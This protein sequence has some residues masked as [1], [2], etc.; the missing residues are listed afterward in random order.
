MRILLVEDDEML[1]D[2]LQQSLTNQH[3][4]VDLATDGQ[5]GLDYA[6]SAEYDLIVIDVGLPR[7]DGITLCQRLRSLGC[8]TPI[9]LMTARDATSDRIRGLDAGADD[10]LTKPLNLAE[11]Q[12]RVRALLRRSSVSTS[13]V[14]QVGQLCLNPS[15]C[16]VSYGDKPLSLTPK[17]YSLLELFLRNPARVF[18]R[19]QILQHLWT[20]DD[21]PLEESVKAHIKGLRQKLKTAGAVDWIENVYGIG[22]RLKEGV[23]EQLEENVTGAIAKASAK[24]PQ[25]EAP[26]DSPANLAIAQQQFNQAMERLWEQYGDLMVQRLHVLRRMATAVQQDE[27]TAELRRDAERA[28]HKLAGVLGMFEKDDGT[29]LAREIEDI[30]DGDQV[31]KTTQKERLVELVSALTVLMEQHL[32]ESFITPETASLLLIDVDPKLGQELQALGRSQGR[33]WYQSTTQTEVET[34]LRSH[35]PELVVLAIDSLGQSASLALLADLV[36]RTPAIPVL[37]LANDDDLL[38]RVTIARSGGQGFLV[39]PVTA[40]QVWETTT[41]LLQRARSAAINVLVVDDDPVFLG[42]VRSL[43]EPWGIHMTG[44]DDP[45]R[46]W[47]TLQSVQPDL[48]ILDVEMPELSGIELC[49]AVRT[50]P[51]WQ[52]LP[53]LFLTAHKDSQIVQQVFAAGAD[54]FIIKPVVGPELLTRINN[55]LERNRLLKTLSTTEPITGLANQRQSSQV[56]E[57][58]LQQATK[59]GQPFSLV[60]LSIADLRQIN[61]QFS[62]TAGNQVLQQWGR[63]F[64]TAFRGNEIVGYWGNGEFVVGLP[65]VTQTAVND[66]LADVLKTLRRQV[67]TAPN[68]KRFQA[69]CQV[70]IADSTT[71]NPTIHTLYQAAAVLI[72]GMN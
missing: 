17:E 40:A 3:Y 31:L 28:A 20:F 14:L 13:P 43:L 62:H 66:H 4:V 68:G 58:L 24:Q 37:V 36:A 26:D 15:S 55:R 33:N 23:G 44:L 52:E 63:T 47:E 30:L 12:A 21:P 67:F 38:D 46:F 49:Q 7:M 57:T 71:A 9:L 64:Q 10:Y 54:E 1:I 22:Y 32:P 56:M 50:D 18:S 45:L 27:L 41:Q 16:Q 51:T 69:T 8:V 11:L 19:G 29:T 25:T 35:T 39:K 53:I 2:V 72:P 59:S 48:L 70:A 34:W 65:G 60:I 42:L 61:L 6:E 5:A